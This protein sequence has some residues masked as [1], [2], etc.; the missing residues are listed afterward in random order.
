MAFIKDV[1]R[2]ASCVAYDIHRFSKCSSFLFQV[3]FLE[4]INFNVRNL[5]MFDQLF[6]QQGC[7]FMLPKIIDH[8]HIELI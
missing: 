3:F 1:V 2:Y 8:F 5:A 6:Q 4:N 7:H